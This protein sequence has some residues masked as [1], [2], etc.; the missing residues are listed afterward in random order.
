MTERWIKSPEVKASVDHPIG[1]RRVTGPV[2]I[3]FTDENYAFVGTEAHVNDNAPAIVFADTEYLVSVHL[4]RDP[5]TGK[6]SEHDPRGYE[7]RS[8]SVLGKEAPKTHRMAIVAA[9]IATVEKHWTEDV[10]R[11]AKYARAAQELYRIVPTFDELSAKL[12][13]LG[14]EIAR[15]RKVMED[16]APR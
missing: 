10:A 5:D 4:D 2:R 11:Q 8:R 15:L 14:E 7:V 16:N 6:W 12:V 3:A 13:N 1:S 9:L